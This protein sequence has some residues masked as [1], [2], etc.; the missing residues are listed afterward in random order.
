MNKTIAA[1]GGIIIIGIIGAIVFFT[2]QNWSGTSTVATSTVATTT[3]TTPVIQGNVDTRT[4]GSPVATTNATV[5]PTDTTAVVTGTV[6]PMGAM[7]T[8][9]YEYG[10][11][12]NLG[13]KTTNQVIGSGYAAIPTPAYLTGLTK[14]ST[15]YFRLVAQ[16]EYGQSSGVQNTVR[17]TEGTPPPVGGIPTAKSLAATNVSRT[18]ANIKGEVN[19]NKAATTYWFEYGRTA[20]LGDMTSFTSAGNGSAVVAASATL[21]NLEAGTTYYFRL[22]SQNQ[23]GTVN[24]ATL[25]F[26]TSGPAAAAPSA[27]TRTTT[28]VEKNTAT[29]RAT[30]D[31]NGAETTYW[32]EYSNDSLLG[33]VLLKTTAQ[34]PAGSGTNSTSVEANVSELVSNMTYYVRAVAQNSQGTVRG[35]KV[36]FKTK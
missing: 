17:T 33:S 29:F 10:A 34:K 16:N 23:F 13:N 26:K 7:T 8:Y 31:P 3:D 5:A 30:I 20:N 24:G 25:T 28:N 22:N 4:P 32:F 15:Y 21:A 14:S 2:N 6:I 35:D 36:S 19:P 27:T 18:T 9:W 1:V 11:S 12:P